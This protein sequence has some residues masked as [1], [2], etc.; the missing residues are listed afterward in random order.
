[1]RQVLPLGRT[2]DKGIYTFQVSTRHN[3]RFSR[4]K[5]WKDMTRL[6]MSRL[7]Q[8]KRDKR[9]TQHWGL[10]DWSNRPCR[11]DWTNKA[12]PNQKDGPVHLG[13]PTEQI[14]GVSFS[15]FTLLGDQRL[16]RRIL[17]YNIPIIYYNMF[18][19]SFLCLPS[20]RHTCRFPR[21]TWRK[22]TAIIQ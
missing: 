7:E 8:T 15:S 18:F 13:S 22:M 5:P 11:A 19:L 16:N 4:W 17:H 9:S 10:I 14:K 3:F 2:C 20:F 6:E 21:I 12:R 1:M